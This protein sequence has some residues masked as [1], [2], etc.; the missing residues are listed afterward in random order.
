MLDLILNAVLDFLRI[1]INL[2]PDGRQ[3]HE[4]VSLTQICRGLYPSYTAPDWPV[5]VFFSSALT[6]SKAILAILN[7]RVVYDMTVRRLNI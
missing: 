6:P 3:N 5:Y 4:S 7:T 1:S 2:A